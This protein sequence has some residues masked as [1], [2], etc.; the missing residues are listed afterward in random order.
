MYEQ[1]SDFPLRSLPPPC[2]PRFRTSFSSLHV[3]Q[4]KGLRD[5][6]PPTSSRAHSPAA[7]VSPLYALNPISR[8]APLPTSPEAPPLPGTLGDVLV[9]PAMAGSL[10][11]GTCGPSCRHLVVWVPGAAAVQRQNVG[12]PEPSEAQRGTEGIEERPV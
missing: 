1:N 2:P 6:A 5:L 3:A 9:P 12:A 11:R 4:T 10:P 7:S 8:L